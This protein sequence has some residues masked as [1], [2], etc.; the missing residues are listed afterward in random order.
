MNNQLFFLVK[1]LLLSTLISAL[2]KYVG[3][4]FLFPPTAVN[5]LMMVLL[6]TIFMI[7][8]LVLPMVSKRQS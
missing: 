5:A 8:F 1:L 4:I 3:P 2:I 6:P 7:S